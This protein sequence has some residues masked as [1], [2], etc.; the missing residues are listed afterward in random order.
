MAHPDLE[1]ARLTA[2]RYRIRPSVRG[3]SVWKFFDWTHEACG[4]RIIVA[5]LKTRD[6]ATLHLL[7]RLGL[8]EQAMPTPLPPAPAYV[9]C[10]DA[11]YP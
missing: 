2:S 10:T 9:P 4:W 1:H 6:D 7:K 5:D 3:W 11:E 8:T